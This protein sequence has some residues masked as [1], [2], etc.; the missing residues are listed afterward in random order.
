MK[1]IPP[2]FLISLLL[3]CSQRNVESSAQVIDSSAHEVL[4]ENAPISN[5]ESDN[6]FTISELTDTSSL[7]EVYSFPVF[8][9][10]APEKPHEKINKTLQQE[11]LQLIIG[12][13]DSSIFE[14]IWPEPGS[15]SGTTN[16]GFRIIQNTNRILAIEIN[17]EGCGAYCEGYSTYY[18]F[19]AQT[20]EV[21]TMEKLF[22]ES[23]LKELARITIEG[24]KQLIKENIKENPADEDE[25]ITS[26]MFQECFDRMTE[27]YFHHKFYL[28]KDKIHFIGERCSNHAMRAFDAIDEFDDVMSFA[29]LNDYLSEYGKTLMFK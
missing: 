5:S 18:N 6:Y 8:N 7:D 29:E 21:I 10:D 4:S 13:Q 26:E 28:E 23:G 9:S 15:Y 12:E 2:L 11:E 3:S 27:E 17:Q 1:A 22:T 19:D 16:F 24:R 25:Q 14:K 20:G